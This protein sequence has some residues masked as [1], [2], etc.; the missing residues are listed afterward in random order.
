MLFR[1]QFWILHE[2]NE[3]TNVIAADGDC[4]H[5]PIELEIDSFVMF[6]ALH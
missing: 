5:L 1:Q 6:N 2:T 4:H 3:R